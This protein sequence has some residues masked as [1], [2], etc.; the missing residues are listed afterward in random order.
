[1]V[2]D[3]RPR[4]WPWLVALAVAGLGIL[5]IVH[6]RRV[7]A[8]EAYERRY[9]IVNSPADAQV[10]E[11]ALQR[12]RIRAV[13][14][15]V[16]APPSVDTLQLE[17]P[18]D[19]GIEGLRRHRVGDVE[20]AKA[21]IGIL[22]EEA[23]RGRYMTADDRTWVLAH[24]TNPILVAS[25]TSYDAPALPA[26][27]ADYHRGSRSGVAYLYDIDGALLCAGSY[28]AASSEHVDLSYDPDA[29]P[30][31]YQLS[32][33]RSRLVGDLED[34]TELSI[35]NRLRKVRAVSE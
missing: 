31:D 10:I 13:I 6:Y 15:G 2:H 25:V 24:L 19:V 26:L 16:A 34:Q 22:L 3:I 35:A 12:W 5:E 32:L 29:F 4:R 20:L 18:C 27:G 17:E 7:S 8:Q 9:P 1:M 23:Q 30:R 28:D 21:I 33:T 11:R 14:A